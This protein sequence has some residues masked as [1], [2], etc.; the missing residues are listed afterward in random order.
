[1]N[2]DI[3]VSVIIPAYNHEQFVQ[4]TILSIIAQ[5][6][7][8]IELIVIDDGSKDNTW[9]KINELKSDC[10]QRFTR[11]HF[12]TQENR[13]TCNTL[14]KLISL[15]KGDYVYFIASDDLAKPQAIE[16]Q[17]IAITKNNAI[18]AVGNNEI[19]DHNSIAIGWDKKRK[20]NCAL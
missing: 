2:K 11:V 17:I 13:G 10:E 8:N 20:S 15:T 1:M 7:K 12:E 16:K 18:V 14:N 4:E 3:L 19:I 5:T 6:Y 9:N